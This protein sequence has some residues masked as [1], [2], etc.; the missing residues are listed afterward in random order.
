M[1][2]QIYQDLAKSGSGYW[3]NQGR[4]HLVTG[5]FEKYSKKKVAYDHSLKIFDI[6]CAAGGTLFY[7]SK[8]GDVWGLDAAPDALELCQAWGIRQDRLLLGDAEK[9]TVVSDAK[10]DLVTAVEIIEHLDNPLR[11]VSEIFRVLKPGGI[12][13]ITVPADMR[14]WSERD[15]RLE[16]RRRYTVSQLVDQVSQSEFE[17]LKA[18]YANAFYYWPYRFLLWMRRKKSGVDVPRVKTNTYDANPFM[19]GL[20]VWLLKLETWW[21]LHSRLPWGVSAVC[22]CRKKAV[23]GTKA[24]A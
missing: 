7:L 23:S 3:W 5:L 14:L 20:F 10:F 21:I 13:I 24:K 2:K 15:V 19:S 9:M 1:D 11:A 4:E 16:H 17:I 18:S 12:L 22:V 8:W 6:G